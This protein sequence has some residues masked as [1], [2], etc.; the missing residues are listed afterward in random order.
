MFVISNWFWFVFWTK[1]NY[2]LDWHKIVK[3]PPYK[4]V[5]VP[6]SIWK[7]KT[8]ITVFEK[9][10]LC[11][12]SSANDPLLNLPAGHGLLEHDRPWLLFLVNL[13]GHTNMTMV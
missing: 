7:K 11:D 2:F 4:K 10:L 5:I 9:I 1:K 12:K 13:T 8:S 6:P 3:L